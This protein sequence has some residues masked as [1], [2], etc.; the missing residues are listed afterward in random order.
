MAW[1][2]T[3]PEDEATGDLG[4][5][6]AAARKRAGKVFQVVKIHSLRPDVMRTFMELYIKLMH[7]P[8]GLTRLERELVA[9]VVSRLNECHY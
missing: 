9:T 7:A 5:Q 2:E 1:I 8:S 3:V 4:R 6:Y